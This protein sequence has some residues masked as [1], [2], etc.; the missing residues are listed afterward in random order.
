MAEKRMFT[1][2][3]VDSDAFLDMPLS[4]QALYFHLNMQADDDGFVNNPKRI[5]RVIGASADDLKLL[6]AKR[7]VLGFESGIIVVKHWRMHNA[8]RKD[9]KTETVYQDELR[10]LLIKDNG[11]YTELPEEAMPMLATT[12]QPN[13][14]QMTT[15]C[16][17]NDGIGK[18]RIDKDRL[19]KERIGSKEGYQFYGNYNNVKLTEKQFKTIQDTFE[20][21]TALLDK[22]SRY[23]ANS[24]KTFTNHF[25]LIDKITVEDKWPKKQI[26]PKQTEE[27][28]EGVPMPEEVRKKMEVWQDN[29]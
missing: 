3:I 26:K 6:I 25:A 4:T 24:E 23:L 27:P 13:D 19:G 1:K 28:Y 21:P 29:M 20:N 7:F 14:N 11:S 18:D 8:I 12:C 15:T 22:V 17:P 10:T 5:Q 9:R 16:Q 2:K